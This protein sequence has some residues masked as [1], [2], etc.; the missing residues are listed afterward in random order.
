MIDKS[1]IILAT[2]NEHK[3][4]EIRLLLRGLGVKLEAL[5][6]GLPPVEE[7]GATFLENAMIKAV[8]YSRATGKLCLAEDSGIEVDALGGRPGV[9]S[10]RYSGGG[11]E[12]NNKKLLEELKDVPDEKRTCRY[13]AVAVVAFGDNILFTAEGT[14]EGRV[15]RAPAGASGFGYDPVFFVPEYGKTM[16]ELGMRIKNRIS[17]RRKALEGIRGHI[18][19][20]LNLPIK[21]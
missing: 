1:R 16:A 5:P 11:D 2:R 18:A 13:R 20:F 10:S 6:E 14:C 19:K 3:I 7:T 21:K 4:K 12:E 15:A 8:E 9:H 17:H